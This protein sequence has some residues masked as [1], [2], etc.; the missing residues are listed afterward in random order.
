MTARGRPSAR[1]RRRPAGSSDQPAA[2]APMRTGRAAWLCW[3]PTDRPPNCP[4]L[5]QRRSCGSSP[6]RGASATCCSRNA[7][8]SWSARSRRPTRRH[9]RS[10]PPSDA[11]GPGCA[12]STSPRPTPSRTGSPPSPLG[13]DD[14]LRR[15]TAAAEL[16][17][18]LAWLDG[19]AATRTG[20]AAASLAGR[21]RPRARP[22]GARA[23]PRR[24]G[25]STSDPRSSGCSRCSPPIRAAPTRDASSSTSSGAR[26]TSADRGRSTSTSAGCAPR[27]SPGPSEPAYLVT[28]R[29][30]GY[31]L[32]E[33]PDAP[34][35]A[36]TGP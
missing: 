27:S 29:G 1:G 30:V 19:R 25:R 24:A 35:R 15:T 36:L 20:S 26:P 3:P 13:F 2:P 6:T 12:P 11:G 14:A 7:R 34:R 17:G 33:P 31:R 8:G 32:D 21:R 28:V 4:D 18:R 5:V 10:S 23:P 9:S 22:R 16:A